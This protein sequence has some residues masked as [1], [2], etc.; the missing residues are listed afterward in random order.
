[1][2]SWRFW[3]LQMPSPNPEPNPEPI[4][5][6]VVLGLLQMRFG[7]ERAP[8]VL[9]PSA[10]LAVTMLTTSDCCVP[11]LTTA[12]CLPLPLTPT[13]PN[14]AELACP[15]IQRLPRADEP[16]RAA[17]VTL[18]LTPTLTLTLRTSSRCPGHPDPYPN[19]DPSPNPNPNSN[20][21]PNPNPNPHQVR[22]AAMRTPWEASLQQAPPPTSPPLPSP[23]PHYSPPKAPPPLHRLSLRHRRPLHFASTGGRG[24]R[25]SQG[26]DAEAHQRTRAARGGRMEGG[27]LARLTPPAE[28]RRWREWREWR[29]WRKG[30]ARAEGAGAVLQII[31]GQ[32]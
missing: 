13:D 25:G 3:G 9:L 26:G 23:H 14:Q 12:A 6:Q 10:V 24:A 22:A 29:R 28:G 30:E 27:L 11:V 16:T 20:P 1:M 32:G 8:Q 19:P 5:N 17:Q 31:E 4:P 21:N 15:R 7:T 2:C 18:T